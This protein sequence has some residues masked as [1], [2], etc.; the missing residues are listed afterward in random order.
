MTSISRTPHHPSYHTHND[1]HPFSIPNTLV[2][3]TPPSV[4]NVLAPTTS[5]EPPSHA[6]KHYEAFNKLGPPNPLAR[7]KHNRTPA[8]LAY[9]LSSSRRSCTTPSFLGARPLAPDYQFTRLSRLEHLVC[10]PAPGKA[11]C[12]GEREFRIGRGVR[13]G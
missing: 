6:V 10:R 11:C 3:H 2:A 9:L 8:S 13:L 7:D 4:R 12:R 5:A 1:H